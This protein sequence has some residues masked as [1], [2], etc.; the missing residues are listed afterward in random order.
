[1][2]HKIFY[3]LKYVLFKRLFF[4]VLLLT[5]F[6][7]NTKA[8]SGANDPNFNPG[9]GANNLVWT[10]AIQNDG[11]II[12]G[13]Q[14]TSYNGTT[15]NYIT[16]LNADGTLDPTFNVG[17]GASYEVWNTSIHSDGK[18]IVG[19]WFTSFNGILRNNIV[20]LNSD[21]TLDATFNPGTGTD[22]WVN[23]TAIQND[24]KIIIGGY[25]TT[26]NETTRK[27]IARINA[28]GSLDTVFNP[29]TGSYGPVETTA[30]QSDGK[31]IIGGWF[32]SYNET[33]SHNIARLNSDGTLD[34]T[35]NTGTGAY[36]WVKTTAI[37]SDGKI[38][39][40]GYFTSY[41]GTARNHIARLNADGTLDTTFNPGTGANNYIFTTSIQSDGKI[42]IGGDFTSY[43]GTTTNRIARLNTDGTLDATFNPGTG[44]DDRVITTAIQSDGKIL[45]GGKF[46]SY[47]GINRNRI[48]RILI[49]DDGISSIQPK[50]ILI[51]P[52]PVSNELNIEIEGNKGLVNY[53]IFNSIGQVV[54]KGKAIEKTTIQT[55]NFA[56]GIY[57]I[58]LGK[59]PIGQIGDKAFEI[60]K[61]VKE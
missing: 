51:Y 55:S 18:I 11:K 61:I 2:K 59:L 46:T 52:N 14:F 60:K 24:G 41:N 8:Q 9:T 35:F 22:D 36:G 30:I 7:I 16:R 44:V 48:A 17:T 3:L 43:N 47:D 4:A 23:T 40:G 20:R 25:F 29:G 39:I 31:I 19:G 12:I 37:Q 45:I 15:K 32:N 10:T 53:E 13:G 27:G 1:M 58:K 34:N 57:L 21:G 49:S 50:A 33:T 54:F 38:I 28:D 5:A 26:Y 42:I 6:C 56:P